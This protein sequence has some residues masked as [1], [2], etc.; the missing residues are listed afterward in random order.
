MKTYGIFFLVGF[1]ACAMS[2][3]P[4]EAPLLAKQD[5]RK[6]SIDESSQIFKN[7][8]EEIEE[9]YY[10]ETDPKL[11]TMWAIREM[12]ERLNS[13]GG[14]TWVE[15]FAPCEKDDT[16]P[17]FGFGIDFT[18]IRGVTYITRV[19][20][21]STAFF[22]GVQSGD[23]LFALDDEPIQLLSIFDI[24]HRLRCRPD[25]TTLSLI[26]GNRLTKKRLK[27]GPVDRQDFVATILSNDL[28]YLYL[29]NL[30]DEGVALY[31]I[32]SISKLAE[33]G[34]RKLIL[35]LRSMSGGQLSATTIFLSMFLPPEA[36]V[37]TPISDRKVDEPWRVPRWAH[38]SHVP[39]VVLVNQFTS[40]AGE[41][42]ALTLQSY[43]RATVIGE[44]TT[45]FGTIL[46]SASL[47]EE[48]QL[49]LPVF[50]Y[51]GPHGETVE[52]KGVRPDIEVKDTNPIPYYFPGVPD[53]ILD[54]AIAYLRSR[55]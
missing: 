20:P 3:T 32:V 49:L 47:S 43:G 7:A 34:A 36:L 42:I 23:I 28:G 46:N 45:G 8:L 17:G 40:S 6:Q 50:V 52:G 12:L 41:I 16:P 38:P 14:L 1:T 25:E 24:A 26:H 39:I 33:E 48:A 22:A 13:H 9:R 18:R 21:M 15:D 19:V 11:L 10:R 37:I 54:T 5:S 27:K 35:D 51:Y 44:R 4:K 55:E 29:A 53:K 30:N 31:N 2:V